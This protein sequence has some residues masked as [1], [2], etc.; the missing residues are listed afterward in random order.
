MTDEDA[1]LA[2]IRDE[3]DD[4]GIR[5]I[6]A[7]FWERNGQP[8]RAEFARA[9]LR[10]DEIAHE[11]RIK[12]LVYGRTGK[13]PLCAPKICPLCDE[14]RLLVTKSRKLWRKVAKF[15]TPEGLIFVNPTLGRRRDRP[16]FLAKTNRG[17]IV[18][19]QA[20]RGG[21]VCYEGSWGSWK[22]YAGAIRWPLDLVYLTSTPSSDTATAL[23]DIL[24]GREFLVAGVV[25]VISHQEVGEGMRPLLRRRWSWVREWRFPGVGGGID[26]DVR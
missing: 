20:E 15:Y 1:L 4:R 7:D 24:S 22:H 18:M 10:L 11:T 25:V 13:D 12:S 9:Q 16:S 17:T 23:P 8:E 21:L 5:N 6:L 2:A 14:A 19:F 3:P 26:D